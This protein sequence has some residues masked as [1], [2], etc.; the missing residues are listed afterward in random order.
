MKIFLRREGG[1]VVTYCPQGTIETNE[2]PPEEARLVT[3]ALQ[4]EK[5]RGISEP[6]NPI[7]E[8]F[9]YYIRLQRDDG[10]FEEFQVQE[11]QLEPKSQEALNLLIT[12]IQR[13]IRNS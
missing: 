8:G 10:S 9:K 13:S 11:Q 6:R 4:P 2:L 7:P 5:L 1:Q 3:N 12:R